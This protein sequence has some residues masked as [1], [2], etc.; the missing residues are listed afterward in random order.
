V[1]LAEKL[2]VP[3]WSPPLTERSGFLE[4]HPQFQASEQLQVHDVVLVV[5]EQP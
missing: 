4:N 5:G 1:K 3:V 2:S